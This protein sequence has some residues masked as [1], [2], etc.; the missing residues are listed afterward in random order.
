MGKRLED[1]CLVGPQLTGHDIRVFDFSNLRKDESLVV[2]VAGS[3]FGW[4]WRKWFHFV[5]VARR[6]GFVS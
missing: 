2:G 4:E 3:G 5:R 1:G 6:N